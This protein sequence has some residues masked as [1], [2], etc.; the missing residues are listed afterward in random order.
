MADED[1]QASD[2]DNKA[3][4]P[5]DETAVVSQFDIEASIGAIY[6]RFM[7]THIPF[8]FQTRQDHDLTFY[9]LPY[10]PE[11]GDT[12]LLAEPWRIVLEMIDEDKRMVLGLDLY[13]DVILGRGQ[14]R[15]GHIILNLDPYNAQQMGVS[16]E[17]LMLRPT[18]SHLYAIDQGSTNGTLVNGA[19]L[20]RG[21]A[22][23]LANEDLIRVGNLMMV[24]YVVQTPLSGQ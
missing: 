14:S 8:G 15:P 12:L 2:A 22:T 16:R 18:R 23:R 21:I 11:P 9:P 7:A 3:P 4:P 1:Q 10:Q 20:G 19:R 24:L 5:A 13:G 17:H 6:N